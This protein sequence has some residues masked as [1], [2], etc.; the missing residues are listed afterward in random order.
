MSSGWGPSDFT[1][2]CP[3]LGTLRL[4]VHG[5][6]SISFSS[7][8]KRQQPPSTIWAAY[9]N[10]SSHC[11]VSVSNRQA[12]EDPLQPQ[13]SPSFVTRSWGVFSHPLTHVTMALVPSLQKV[14]SVSSLYAR[15]PHLP[16]SLPKLSATRKGL[17]PQEASQG[18][19]LDAGRRHETCVSQTKDFFYFF[20]FFKEE[21]SVVYGK[22][23]SQNF[24]FLFLLF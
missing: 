18:P 15:Y 5:H 20:F 23:N 10:P 1:V 17:I 16:S 22:S 24:L 11:S 7:L 14:T 6:N 12:V 4:A 3:L 13:P 21:I 8:Q 19:F 2:T 9:H